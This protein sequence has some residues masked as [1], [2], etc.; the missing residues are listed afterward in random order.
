MVCNPTCRRDV[1]TFNKA[2]ILRVF[3]I[4][5]DFY[6]LRG[7]FKKPGF[8]FTRLSAAYEFLQN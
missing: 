2:Q 7:S 8:V 4:N 1:T 6:Q 3:A 5:A